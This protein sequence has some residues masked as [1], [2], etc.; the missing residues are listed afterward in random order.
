MIVVVHLVLMLSALFLK[1]LKTLHVMKCTLLIFF[2]SVG[3]LKKPFAQ[4]FKA[5]GTIRVN[6]INNTCLSSAKFTEKKPR[7]TSDV[8]P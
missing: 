3:L 7:G 6:R 1:L 2:T 5:T 4:G 8:C